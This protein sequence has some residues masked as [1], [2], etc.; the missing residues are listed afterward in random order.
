MKVTIDMDNLEHVLEK[1]LGENIEKVV[2]EE[3]EK[4]LQSTISNC[5]KDVIDNIAN[6]SIETY[7]NDYIKTA[8]LK[9][10]GGLYPR[11][12]EKVYTVEQYLRKELAE[13]LDS[14]TLTITKRNYISDCFEKKK[15]TFEEFIKESFNFDE[16]IKKKLNEFSKELKIEITEILNNNLNQTAKN[17]LS[18][19]VFKVLTESDVYKKLT[20]NLKYISE[21]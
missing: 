19:T 17:A 10:G 2:R 14:K 6:K 18:E 20:D 13:I 9:T 21:K 5:A 16:I 3:A 7:V 11:E 15:V 12:E 8:T 4:I 1:V